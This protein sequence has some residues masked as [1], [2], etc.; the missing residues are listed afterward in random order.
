MR[1]VLDP[2]VGHQIN[3]VLEPDKHQP[4][5]GILSLIMMR[6]IVQ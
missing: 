6:D 4:L 1:I 3:V 5:M 2:N